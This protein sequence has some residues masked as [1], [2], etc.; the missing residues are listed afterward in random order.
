MKNSVLFLLTFMYAATADTIYARGQTGDPCYTL[1]ESFFDI[2]PGT[3]YTFP[4]GTT[5]TILAHTEYTSTLLT[6][7]GLC[8]SVILTVLN[9]TDITVAVTVTDNV[10]TAQQ[11]NAGYQWVDCD[12]AY[13]PINGAN[14][15]SYTATSGNFAVII[16]KGSCT[17][18]SACYQTGTVGMHAAD[19]GAVF[20]YP[21][22]TNGLFKIRTGAASNDA[23]II[24]RNA[25]G[26]QVYA[27][28]LCNATEL[29]VNLETVAG[30]YFMELHTQDGLQASY[31]L[32]KE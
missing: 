14:N 3:D 12:N 30:L 11:G 32:L 29:E 24:I 27:H 25:T 4:D 22:P 6:A 16:Y 31:K 23:R 15:Q 2:C 19:A 8:D 18:T 17:D 26:Q 5:Q 7:D 10:L 9:T 21:N 1:S 20:V 13:A 28:T